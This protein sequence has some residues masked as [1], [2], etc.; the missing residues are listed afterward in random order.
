MRRKII[1][2]VFT[3][4]FGLVALF[5]NDYRQFITYYTKNPGTN[6]DQG[7]RVLQ[8]LTIPYTLL[9]NISK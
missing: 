9:R 5:T 6:G 1:E 4:F 8:S 2:E 7:N 3:S